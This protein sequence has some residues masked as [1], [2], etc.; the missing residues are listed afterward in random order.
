[1]SHRRAKFLR[2]ELFPKELVHEAGADARAAARE[3]G[4]TSKPL[5]RGAMLRDSRA[6]THRTHRTS[7]HFVPVVK[8]FN[9]V[10]LKVTIPHVTTTLDP[11]CP[12]GSMKAIIGRMS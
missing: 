6:Y 2:Q 9:W 10:M 8:A 4:V 11:T 3:A 5:S 12:E 1:M 7:D